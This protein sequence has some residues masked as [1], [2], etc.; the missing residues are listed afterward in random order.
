MHSSPSKNSP[1]PFWNRLLSVVKAWRAQP[2]QVATIA[3]SSAFVLEKIAQRACIEQASRIVELGPG[4]GGTTEALLRQMGP[5]GRLLAIE[6]TAAFEA[7]LKQIDDP[8]LAVEMGDAVDLHRFLKRHH[9][10][11]VD[12]VVS[13]IPFSSIA[14]CDGQRIVQAVHACLRPGGTFIAYQLHSDLCRIAEPLF[15]EVQRDHVVLNLPPLRIFT[16]VKD[17]EGCGTV[18][19][20]APASLDRPLSAT[21]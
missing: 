13:G 14:K 15:G 3:P 6:K 2:S 7:I 8:R 16:W 21:P 4:E 11:S 12:V 10:P 17:V 20:P 5:G 1:R 18:P 19:A 9:M